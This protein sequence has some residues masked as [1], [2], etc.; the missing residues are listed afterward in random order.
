MRS[1]WSDFASAEKSAILTV[2]VERSM[3]VKSGRDAILVASNAVS[4]ARSWR[5]GNTGVLAWF[6]REG[7]EQRRFA[8][9]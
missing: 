7:A 6:S 8:A 2:V 3:A 4:K 9:T 5:A 1:A